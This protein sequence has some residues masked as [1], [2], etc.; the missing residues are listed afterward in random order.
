MLRS[1]LM[2]SSRM[3]FRVLGVRLQF[4]VLNDVLTVKGTFVLCDW[5]VLNFY[6]NFE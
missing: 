3:D 2:T 5:Y 6:S 4:A 1:S